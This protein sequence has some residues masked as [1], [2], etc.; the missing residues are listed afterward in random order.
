MIGLD[1]RVRPVSA[2]DADRLQRMFARLSPDTVH[3]RFFTLMPRLCETMLRTLCEVDPEAGEALVVVVGDEI[4]ALASYHR[5]ADAPSVA[6]V[7]VLVE[8]GWQHSGLGSRLVRALR[9]RA[10]AR[11]VERFH[12]DLL[13]SNRPVVGMIRRLSPGARAAFVDGEL[14]Y[15][16]PLAPAA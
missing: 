4:V 7:A 14:V 2:D 3:R 11:G 10:L 1:A 5:L 9:R 6:D 13:A 15:D 8:D 12:A 16:L